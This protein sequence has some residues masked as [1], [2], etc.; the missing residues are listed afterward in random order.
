MQYE[1]G[2]HPFVIWFA[3]IIGNL[4]VKPTE[5]VASRGPY[6]P[7]CFPF[8]VLLA[9]AVRQSLSKHEFRLSRRESEELNFLVHASGFRHDY[10]ITKSDYCFRFIVHCFVHQR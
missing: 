2:W 5:C 9:E 4:S 10:K 7:K 1:Y 8:S 3:L 6:R